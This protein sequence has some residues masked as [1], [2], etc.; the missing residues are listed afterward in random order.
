[1]TRHRS[2]VAAL[3][4]LSLTLPISAQAAAPQVTAK[5]G[6]WNGEFEQT[7]Q[8]RRPLHFAEVPVELE[9]SCP[10]GAVASSL[11][12]DFDPAEGVIDPSPASGQPLD[13]SAAFQEV[14]SQARNLT[15]ALKPGALYRVRVKASCCAALDG[16]GGCLEESAPIE[17]ISDTLEIQPI[18]EAAR[19]IEDG[20]H[21]GGLLVGQT[22][23]LTLYDSTP[24]PG[25]HI[26]ADDLRKSLKFKG[27]GV[28]FKTS[29]FTTTNSMGVR[30]L[31]PPTRTGELE[32]TLTVNGKLYEPG[33]RFLR[34]YTLVSSPFPIE[35]MA[36]RCVL[37]ATGSIFIVEDRA[38]DCLDESVFDPDIGQQ[39]PAASGCS[40]S[41]ATIP[42]LLGV[43][44]LPALILRRR[45]TT[46]D[47]G[48][49]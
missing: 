15:A 46:V 36:E 5:L 11:E 43:L 17:V 1:M 19:V 45:H 12:Y 48:A 2:V 24:V 18:I 23:D 9:V 4:A 20:L 16:A 41:A 40:S 14:A 44:F 25:W 39:A 49:P 42:G 8:D 38:P 37:D 26:E 47:R 31:P 34:D 3:F 13:D 29:D 21:Y 32:V 35:V 10:A 7:T 33:G 6:P 30:Y 28:D 22:L 27:V